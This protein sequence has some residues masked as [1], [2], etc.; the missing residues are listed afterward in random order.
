MGSV[1]V[2]KLHNGTRVL[3]YYL[4]HDGW[5][6]GP[7]YLVTG[8]GKVV[9]QGQAVWRRIIEIQLKEFPEQYEPLFLVHLHR[10]KG[11]AREVTVYLIPPFPETG[12]APILACL[13]EGSNLQRLNKIFNLVVSWLNRGPPDTPAP[14]TGEPRENMAQGT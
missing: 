1:W 9:W 10:M 3:R 8:N 5:G 2:D 14:G 11:G 12:D 13:W 7:V 4:A 6:E